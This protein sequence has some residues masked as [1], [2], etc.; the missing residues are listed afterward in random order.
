MNYKGNLKKLF[1]EKRCQSH[2][3]R[4]NLIAMLESR[5]LKVQEKIS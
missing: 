5:I 4:T 3:P 1:Y 2:A